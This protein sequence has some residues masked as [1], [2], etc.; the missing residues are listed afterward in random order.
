MLVWMLK[1]RVPPLVPARN[2]WFPI[3]TG[4]G[5]SVSCF[6]T[7]HIYT[8][9]SP[10]STGQGLLCLSKIT[11]HTAKTDTRETAHVK[12]GSGERHTEKR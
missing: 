5:S 8:A 3:N 2:P 9:Y 12:G 11:K 7:N 10:L 6:I 1:R 4:N